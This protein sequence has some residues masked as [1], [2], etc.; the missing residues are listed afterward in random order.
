MNVRMRAA[1][2]VLV[3][4]VPPAGGVHGLAGAG[5]AWAQAPAPGVSASPMPA[6]GPLAS[7]T[8]CAT[9]HRTIY[10][11][12]SESMHA[13]SASRPSYL[14]ALEKAGAADKEAARRNC[15]WC[16]APTV[17][18]TGDYELKQSLTKEGV[19]CDFC[20]TVAEVDLDRRPPFD[21]RPGRIKR[22]PLQYAYSEFH[23]T[24]YS[25]LHKTSP[26]LCAACHEYRNA[27]GVAVLSTYTEWRASPYA[28]RGM[29]CQE[30]HMP[31]VPGTT[32]PQDL[33]PS[34]HVINLHRII[35]G[36]G[37]AKLSV[38]L[39]LKFD[40]VTVTSA[41]ADVQVVVTSSRVGHAAPGGFANRALVVAVGVE[42]ASGELLNRRERVYRRQLKDAD[43]RELVTVADL[44]FKAASV[45]EDNRLRPG[46]SRSE[47]FTVPVPAGSRAIVARLEYRDSSDPKGPSTILV[48]EV[49]RDLR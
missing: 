9:C 28:A 24:E 21:L 13:K 27:L 30:C 14:E 32:V 7:A 22:G 12:W 8:T 47:R 44:I 19:S 29:T 42:S 41:S 45:G 39:G 31:L 38:G 48:T 46:E 23:D 5:L 37:T 34:D 4:I 15:V 43:G 40:S 36:S 49:R 11:Y 3:L 2:V 17:L 20:H 16:H 25:P 33:K 10:D 26:L 6:A 18:A 35:G 1:V